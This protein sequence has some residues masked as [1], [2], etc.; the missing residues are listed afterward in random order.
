ME[1]E[2]WKELE[3]CEELD[4]PEY[5]RKADQIIL[6]GVSAYTTEFLEVINPL[7][8]RDA[9]LILAALRLVTY[10]VETACPDAIEVAEGIVTHIKGRVELTTTFTEE[11]M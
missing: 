2:F 9:I 1:R 4:G 10:A 11:E 5:K 6:N 3:T 8:D 7:T